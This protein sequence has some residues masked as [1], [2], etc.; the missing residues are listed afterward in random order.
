[1][2]LP[3]FDHYNSFLEISF[4]I[5]VLFSAWNGWLGNYLKQSNALQENV[6]KL[7]K[8]VAALAQQKPGYFYQFLKVWKWIYRTFYFLTVIAGRVVGVFIAIGIAG[9]L[10]Y[11]R[12]NTPVS[13]GWANLILASGALIPSL[14]LL[15]LG[16]EK[17][18]AWGIRK[19]EKSLDV[20]EENA[21]LKEEV[22]KEKKKRREAEEKLKSLLAPQSARRIRAAFDDRAN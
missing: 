16:A 17:L 1:M 7:E 19:Q 10:F 3:T 5:N 20:Q 11:L 21:Q 9:A 18:L 8:R 14:T 22:E 4:A 6:E 15:L 2:S 13:V 12:G